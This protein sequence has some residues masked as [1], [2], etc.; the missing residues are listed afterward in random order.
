MGRV[1]CGFDGSEPSLAALRWALKEAHLRDAE[2]RVVSVIPRYA[3]E[4]ATA[5]L[6]TIRDPQ[7]HRDH[8]QVAHKTAED[9]VATMRNEIENG[10]DLQ[11]GVTATFGIP[12]EEIINH[13]EGA[14]LIVVGRRGVGGFKRLLLG[15]VSH[16]LVQHAP[17]TVVV[18]RGTTNT[19]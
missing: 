9:A 13:A 16:A 6:G 12:A 8:M 11:I 4:T 18:V 19:K 10:D 5:G 3:R 7:L 1:V 14:E 2:L 17:C 15:S